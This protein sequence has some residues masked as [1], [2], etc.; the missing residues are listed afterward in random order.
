MGDR[1]ANAG[2]VKDS[3]LEVR[4]ASSLTAT[5]AAVAV[6][7]LTGGISLQKP[8]ALYV[9]FPTAPTGTT[10]T[11]LVSLNCTTAGHLLD[12]VHVDTIDD[13]TTYPFMLVLPFPPTEDGAATW[14]V[15]FT[16]GGTSPV[17]ANVEAWV[18]L[19]DNLKVDA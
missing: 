19:A 11:C 7:A 16:T 1:A 2:G 17:Y 6:P 10:P 9:K 13:N 18:G 8:M 4:A 12:I 15:D 5:E 14:T 3:A